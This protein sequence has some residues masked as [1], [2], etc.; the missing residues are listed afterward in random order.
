MSV[1]RVLFVLLLIFASPLIYADELSKALAEAKEECDGE[2]MEIFMASKAG[3][4]IEAHARAQIAQAEQKE[5]AGNARV[6]YGILQKVSS[7]ISDASSKRIQIMETR[8]ENKLGHEEEKNGR[9]NEAFDLFVKSENHLDIKP[10][11]RVHDDSERVMMKLVQAQ[12][13][14]LPA[15][16][17]AFN[18]VKNPALKK[19]LRALALKNARQLLADEDKQ[20]FDAVRISSGTLDTLGK[21]KD[22]LQYVEAPENRLAVERAE[23]RGDT[24]SVETTRHFLSQAVYYYGF[25]G[26]PEKVKLVRDK[27]K[28]LGDEAKGK[29]EGEVAAEYYQIAGLSEQANDL[30]KNTKTKRIEEEGNRK[31]KF[32]KDQANMEKEFGM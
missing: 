4:L 6:A 17:K 19:T 26:K 29:G 13:E 8:L 9:L 12:P 28:K 2:G 15:F 20:F 23:K 27:A 31:Q 18:Y 1:S 24:L 25:A 16:S 30:R 22:W 21:A 10:E 14:D 5:Q 32:K 11:E 7:C 3:Q